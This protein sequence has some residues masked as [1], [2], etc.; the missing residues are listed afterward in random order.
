M[1][2]NS[3]IGPAIV[4]IAFLAIGILMIKYP[5]LVRKY[6]TRMVRYIKDEGEYVA[7]CYV[8]GALFLVLS[9]WRFGDCDLRSSFALI[10]YARSSR[11][12]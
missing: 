5:H 10:Q 9:L 11:S 8:M 6:D 2:Q 1:N 3:M 4:F 7:M 12:R